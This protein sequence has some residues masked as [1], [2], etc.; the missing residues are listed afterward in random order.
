MKTFG[1]A[2]LNPLSWVKS[3]I[4]LRAD[5]EKTASRPFFGLTL[6]MYE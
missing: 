3:R 5:L 6:Q 2:A 4:I 1:F